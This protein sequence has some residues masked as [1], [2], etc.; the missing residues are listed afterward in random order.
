MMKSPEQKNKPL[1]LVVCCQVVDEQHPILGFFV[2]WLSVFARDFARIDVICLEKGEYSLP[3]NVYVHSLKKEEGASKLRQLIV[4]YRVFYQTVRGQKPT[5]V[6]YH[7]GAIYNLLGAPFFLLRGR[8]KFYWWKTHGTVTLMS[9]LALLFVDRVYTAAEASFPIVSSKR[10]VIGHA[11]DTNRFSLSEKE[12][13]VDLLFVGRFSRIK[14][15]EQVVEVAALLAQKNQVCRVVLLGSQPDQQYAT[16][17]RALIAE[18]KLTSVIEIR[19]PVAQSELPTL[20]QSAKICMNPSEHDGLDK[21]LLE[22][23]ACGALPLTGNESFRSMLSPYNLFFNKGDIMAFAK[24]SEELL[25]ASA[26]E[27]ADL[28]TALRGVVVDKHDINSLTHRLF[29]V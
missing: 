12:R 3:E 8:T 1:T 2:S 26:N 28:T 23:M 17:V 14:R 16:E 21:V 4:F 9:R 13:P 10:H 27:R 7:M 11:I 19:P 15:V 18:K 5:F 29:N 20:Y 24:R 25:L 22:A 6:F